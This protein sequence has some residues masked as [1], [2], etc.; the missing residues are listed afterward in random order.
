VLFNSYEFVFF[1]LPVVAIVFFWIAG[2]SQRLAAL[3]LTA[4]SLFY[5]GWWNPKYVLLILASIGFN[6]CLGILIARARRDSGVT[7][8][9]WFLLAAAV[10]ANLA[11]LAYFKYANFFVENFNRMAGT[12]LGMADVILPLGIS[13][14]TFTQI[15]FLVDVYRGVAREYNFVHYVLFV[16]YFP[17]L[18]AGPLLHH[19]QMMPQFDD[20]KTYRPDIGNVCVGLTVF[21]I[22]L[23]KKVLLA[24]QFALFANPVFDVAA[25]GGEL[26]LIEAWIG[27][28]AY[29]LQIYF[30]FSGY[31]DMAIGLSK[32]FNVELPVNFNSPYKATSVIEFWRRWHMTLSS[33]LRDY[34]YVPLG[35]NRHGIVRRHFNL[36][37]TMLL[38]GLWHG[39]SW[40]FVIWGGLHGAY[41]VIN[42][43]WRALCQ[44]VQLPRIPGGGILAGLA[45][46]VA[47][48][49][50]WVLFRAEGLQSA[51]LM[52]KGMAGLHGISLPAGF[53]SL[54]P[55]LTSYGI[56]F[57]GAT[58]LAKLPMNMVPGWLTL[59]LMIVW[60]L[61]NT[62]EWMGSSAA[63]GSPGLQRS[64]KPW[65]PNMAYA[66]AFGLMF[67]VSV[68][69][70]HKVSPFIY[71]QF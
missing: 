18:I 42:H 7:G 24:D 1:Y 17:H 46:F 58:P 51:I 15:V 2:I 11:L 16:T 21:T 44:R 28:I 34:L 31:S 43:A 48:T 29:A 56:R 65:R 32:M 23:C 67:A 66:L 26:Q 53:E 54:F 8:R 64:W 70:F 39:A 3:W 13:F 69:N 63:A 19:R 37:V 35:G 41:L 50:A 38:G 36:M 27:A 12:G 61:P 9:V 71:F 47:V 40:T 49:A 6:Y 45:T 30:D 20:P 4:A 57:S 68:A 5:Y 25:K 52:L 59:G 55:E 33:F 10:I 60:A 22:G 62:Q 14:F